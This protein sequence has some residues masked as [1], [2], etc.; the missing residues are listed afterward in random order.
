MSRYPGKSHPEKQN[1][2]SSPPQAVMSGCMRC[3]SRTL[4]HYS[5]RKKEA[6]IPL[7]PHKQKK[8]L[9]FAG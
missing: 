2:R 3:A 6:E 8:G 1:F 4:T 9:R 5:L 7:L